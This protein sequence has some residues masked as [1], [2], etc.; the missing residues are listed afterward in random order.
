MQGKLDDRWLRSERD[1]STRSG[2]LQIGTTDANEMSGGHLGNKIIHA[3]RLKVLH[4]G[5]WRRDTVLLITANEQV[6][7]LIRK[8][9]WIKTGSNRLVEKCQT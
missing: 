6:L 3:Y 8:P 9:H 2:N 5:D 1:Y 4:A 7:F